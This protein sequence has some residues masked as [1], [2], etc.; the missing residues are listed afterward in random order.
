VVRWRLQRVVRLRR[1]HV[2]VHAR[3]VGVGCVCRGGAVTLARRMHQRRPAPL[4]SSKM[5]VAWLRV[6]QQAAGISV[7]ACCCVCT[8]QHRATTMCSHTTFCR[9]SRCVQRQPMACTCQVAESRT[10][11]AT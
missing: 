5:A 1:G 8:G 3:D 9:L 7:S 6:R 4:R 10:R 2:H 11:N